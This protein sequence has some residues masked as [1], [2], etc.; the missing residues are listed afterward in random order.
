MN[1]IQNLTASQDKSGGKDWPA[2][3]EFGRTGEKEDAF[4][5]NAQLRRTLQEL[6]SKLAGYQ[7]EGSELIEFNKEL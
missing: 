4:R 2:I 6:T 7:E 3:Q 1:P 5:E